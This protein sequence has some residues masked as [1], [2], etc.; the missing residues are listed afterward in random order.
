MCTAASVLPFVH[1]VLGEVLTPHAY[2]LCLAQASLAT[3]FKINALYDDSVPRE[4][5]GWKVTYVAPADDE[6][7]EREDEEQEETQAL[8]RL[9]SAHSS[10]W[11]ILELA[12]GAV[13][14]T[15]PPSAAARANGHAA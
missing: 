15:S 7:E 12:R 2:E 9:T 1:D 13:L 5:R 10:A 4:D 14:S 6:G 11:W 8:A 3:S